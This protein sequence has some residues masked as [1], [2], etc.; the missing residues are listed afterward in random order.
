MYDCLK[1]CTLIYYF[2]VIPIYMLHAM[3]LTVSESKKCVSAFLADYNMNSSVTDSKIFPWTQT[4]QSHLF[5]G[6]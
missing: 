3:R 4:N 1:I 2:Q 6:P 5:I